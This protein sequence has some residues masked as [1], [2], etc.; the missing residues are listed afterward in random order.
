MVDNRTAMLVHFA[1]TNEL[2][3]KV[4]HQMDQLINNLYSSSISMLVSTRNVFF[5]VLHIIVFCQH[6]MKSGNFS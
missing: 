3:Q 6:Q 2:L 4:D 1:K 5:L